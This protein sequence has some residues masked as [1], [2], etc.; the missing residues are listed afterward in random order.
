MIEPLIYGSCFLINTCR[1]KQSPFSP[2]SGEKVAVRPDEGGLLQVAAFK[3]G[4]LTQR[5]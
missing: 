2:D 4:P 5:R 3:T 1:V